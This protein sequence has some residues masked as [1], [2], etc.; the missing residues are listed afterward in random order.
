MFPGNI[1]KAVMALV[2]ASAFLSSIVVVNTAITSQD[3]NPAGPGDQRIKINRFTIVTLNPTDGW[4]SKDEATLITQGTLERIQSSNDDW[5]EVDVP[6]YFVSLEF[7]Q[8][9]PNGATIISVKVYIEHHEEEDFPAGDLSW[10]VGTGSLSSPTVL[11]GTTPTIIE[12]QG[13]EAVIEW[14]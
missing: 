6:N 14:D 8:T 10:E 4:D 2:L 5:L 3:L 1:P 7:N 13:N 12:E 9:V 11:G